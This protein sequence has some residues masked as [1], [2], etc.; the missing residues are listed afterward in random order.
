[1]RQMEQSSQWT[2]VPAI[3]SG[4]VHMPGTLTGI[5]RLR[6]TVAVA[7]Y[8]PRLLVIMRWMQEPSHSMAPKGS[9]G[10]G[11]VA[12]PPPHDMLAAWVGHPSRKLRL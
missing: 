11:H 1:M 7:K 12:S 8:S 4:L 2:H 3:L 5:T 10:L 6:L 9:G